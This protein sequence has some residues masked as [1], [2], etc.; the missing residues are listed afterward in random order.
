MDTDILVIHQHR[1]ILDMLELGLQNQLPDLEVETQLTVLGSDQMKLKPK[2][3]I[4]EVEQLSR[5]AFRNLE[6]LRQRYPGTRI[7]VLGSHPRPQVLLARGV[8]TFIDLNQSLDGITER[9]REIVQGRG[10]GLMVRPTEDGQPNS[11]FDRLSEREREV[12]R[13]LCDGLKS[14]DIASKLEISPQTVHSYVSRICEKLE[15][16][17]RQESVFLAMRHQD[18]WHVL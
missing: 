8:H 7:V 5:V 11:V 1:L 6:P 10:S 18:E 12:L 14:V 4:I 17:T 15:V 3:I 2:I 16:E 9:V 13:G